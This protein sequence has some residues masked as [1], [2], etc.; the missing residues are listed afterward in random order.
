MFDASVCI[1]GWKIILLRCW[2]CE[3]W[4]YTLLL[5]IAV[6]SNL[7]TNTRKQHRNVTIS[8]SARFILLQPNC[9]KT[10]NIPYISGTRV[11]VISIHKKIGYSTAVHPPDM[12]TFI[13][14]ATVYCAQQGWGVQIFELVYGMKKLKSRGPDIH[15]RIRRILGNAEVMSTIC[16]SAYFSEHSLFTTFYSKAISFIY[17]L[18]T[19]SR[20]R[21][22]LFALFRWLQ[23]DFRNLQG[24][25][26]M[27]IGYSSSYI[28]YS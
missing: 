15:W 19:D 22:M 2:S 17:A 8:G 11:C 23:V 24:V 28:Q 26:Q 18:R 6:K 13:W 1:S 16:Y 3:E 12:H 20:G 14:F 25:I 5:T 27:W 9:P 21:A 10:P 7:Q 4:L